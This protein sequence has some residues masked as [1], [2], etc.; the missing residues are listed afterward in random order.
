MS[1]EDQSRPRTKSHWSNH[2][3]VGLAAAEAGD[4]KTALA[5]FDLVV[6][7]RG[8]VRY[9]PNFLQNVL[10]LGDEG[11]TLLRHFRNTVEREFERRYRSHHWT[12]IFLR[13]LNACLQEPERDIEFYKVLKAN[14]AAPEDVLL[15]CLGAIIGRLYESARYHEAQEFLSDFVSTIMEL[16]PAK[17]RKVIHSIH[18]HARIAAVQTAVRSGDSETIDSLVSNLVLGDSC[19]TIYLELKELCERDGDS[20]KIPLLS[21]YEKIDIWDRL[22]IMVSECLI[23]TDPELLIQGGAPLDEYSREAAAIVAT[24]QPETSLQDL[25]TDLQR[26]WR[27]Q[28]GNQRTQNLH[29]SAEKIFQTIQP[30]L[31]SL[32]SLDPAIQLS[33]EDAVYLTD[34][35]TWGGGPMYDVVIYFKPGTDL[36]EIESAILTHM[37]IFKWNRG[38]NHVV[39]KSIMLI[40][41]TNPVGLMHSM[42]N[43]SQSSDHPCY[44]VSIYEKHCV[45]ALGMPINNS[46]NGEN[47][48]KIAPQ[49]VRDFHRTIFQLIAHVNQVSPIVSA[50]INTE[51]NGMIRPYTTDGTICISPNL[52]QILGIEFEQLEDS[53]SCF[54]S[55][56][57]DTSE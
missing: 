19:P 20:I 15:N 51:D 9:P 35:Y 54:V 45:R 41:G 22:T 46:T 28:F 53:H 14:A 55:V 2:H 34:P 8:Y 29:E 25:L 43:Q 1:K 18:S 44:C 3:D 48:N 13:E 27:W 4:F 30:F 16:E 42:R 40:P 49:K 56:K 11:R 33:R 12:I 52:P 21:A 23:I 24:L 57:L 37:S 32:D 39:Q 5:E 50:S 31:G 10:S 6:K 38:G 7:Q 36:N 26:I 47:W 17:K